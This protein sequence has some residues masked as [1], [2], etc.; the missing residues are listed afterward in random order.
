MH[1]APAAALAAGD[2][3][4]PGAPAAGAP[5]TPGGADAAQ[6]PPA[7]ATRSAARAA[8]RPTATTSVHE[9]EAMLPSTRVSRALLHAA[10]R[11]V[12]Q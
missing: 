11:A 6:P 9:P 3:V 7:T 1:G 12:V 2:A 10:P 4:G 8:A 5:A